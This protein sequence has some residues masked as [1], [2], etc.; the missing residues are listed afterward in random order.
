MTQK[1]T[2]FEEFKRIDATLTRIRKV[3]ENYQYI[4]PTNLSEEYEKFI[5]KKK[6]YSPQLLYPSFDAKPYITELESLHIDTT[7]KLGTFF[8]WI[9]TYLIS[10]AKSWAQIG[11][12]TFHTSHLFGEVSDDLYSKAEKILQKNTYTP[13]EK[14]DKNITAQEVGHILLDTLKKY[15][16]QGWHV[17]YKKNTGSVIHI[18]GSAKQ[19]LL[20][21]DEL[22]SEEH[23]KKLI[24]HEIETHALRAENGRLQKY[25][26]LI[27]GLPF[28]LATEEG[29]AIYNEEQ[30]NVTP[31]QQ[32]II[33]ARNVIGTKIAQTKGFMEVYKEIRAYCKD[34]ETAF[35][36][37][38]RIKRGLH[39]TSKPGGFLKDH[40]YLQGYFLIKEFI[41]KGGDIKKLYAGKIGIGDI[42]LVEQKII[43]PPQI[44]PTFLR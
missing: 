43:N 34:N 21:K 22:F 33:L 24:V 41:K 42:Y 23:V 25:K 13:P 10:F 8:E 39:D 40:V 29:L 5:A 15:N 28:Y 3:F 36:V 20:R 16:L 30:M 2:S 37:S 31:L 14:K 27:A 32:K 18:N 1:N 19:I 26:I 44:L 17:I 7:S 6:N 38:A 11:T 9:R 12:D 35:K 4:T